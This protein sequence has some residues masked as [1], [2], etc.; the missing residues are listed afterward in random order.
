VTELRKF[1]WS[2]S[3]DTAF[4]PFAAQGFQVGRVAVENRDC[5]S[6]LTAA[7]EVLAEVAGRLLF[8]KESS[9]DL[10]KVGDWAV[11]QVFDVEQRAIIHDL[12]PRK[13][14]FSR[15]TSGKTFDEQVLAAN[16]DVIFIVQSLDSNFSLRRLE[17]SL[18]MVN[19]GGARPAIV[20][21]KTDLCPNVEQKL[22]EVVEIA[23]GAPVLA[24]SAKEGSGLSELQGLLGNDETFAF[25]GSSGVGKSTLINCL[26]GEDV[27]KTAD[28]RR[29]DS[30]GRHTTTR[31]E[32]I[33]LPEGGCLID[34]PGMRE[35]H[36]WHAEEGLQ[37]TFQDIEAL[38]ESCHFSDCTHTKEKSCAV[39]DA[40]EE[41]SLEKSRY[42][43]YMKLQKELDFLQS[44]RSQS[45]YVE[46]RKKDR[47]LGKMYK[48]IQAQQRKRKKLS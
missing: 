10:P 28:V 1:G 20:L 39:L 38:A 43:S 14:K 3:F 35:L 15:K 29:S 16:I 48:Q 33:L 37:E 32:L 36:L 23:G 34:T 47:S 22:A 21:N 26:L 18:V 46:S 12:L 4:Q 24:V 31:R 44:K 2:E 8:T 11:L 30:K 7:G 41:E 6:V 17:R 40:V 19:E 5:Y 13:S 9:A 27:Q 25:I 42:E 45:A